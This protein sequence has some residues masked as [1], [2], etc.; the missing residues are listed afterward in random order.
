MSALRW[1]PSRGYLPSSSSL[2][3]CA[4]FLVLMPL[5][6]VGMRAWDLNPLTSQGAAAPV[7]VALA[8]LVV[9]SALALV[10]RR[11]WVAGAAA[12][13]FAAWCG[14]AVAASLVG[15]PFGYGTMLGDA[16]RMSRAGHALRLEL[17]AERRSGPGPAA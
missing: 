8:A 4:T 15:T 14:S 11:E 2:A 6:V 9:M 5:G 13:V 16:G 17:G 3:A 10:V 12:G 1:G 7:S